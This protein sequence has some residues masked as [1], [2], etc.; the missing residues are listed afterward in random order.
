MAS[1]SYAHP[2]HFIPPPN[3]AFPLPSIPLLCFAFA[4]LTAASPL[5]LATFPGSS[6]A[7]LDY[8]MPPPIFP[9][10]CFPSASQIK[11]IPSQLIP[12]FSF[13]EHIQSGRCHYNT[14]LIGP[15]PFHSDPEHFHCCTVLYSS[16]PLRF[17]SLPSPSPTTQI[18]GLSVR[19]FAVPSQSRAT[20]LLCLSLPGFSCALRIV[21][22]PCQCRTRPCSS[23]ATLV[24]ALPKPRWPSP[25][26]SKPA[27]FFAVAAPP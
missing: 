12:C 8:A 21:S 4:D 22:A 23:K 25:R 15:R 10:R 20:P 14:F 19:I 16:L 2:L 3:S 5:L 24:R 26:L 9:T 27:P 1:Q 13:S 7:C 18:H 17:N 6:A 11:A